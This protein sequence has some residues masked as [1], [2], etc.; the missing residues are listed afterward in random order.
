MARMQ[1][2][3][4]RHP[5]GVVVHSSAVGDYEVAATKQKIASNQDELVLRLTPTPKILDH[6]KRWAPSSRVV[7]FKAASPET[8]PARL[9]EIAQAQRRRTGS[10]LVFANVIGDLERSVWLV[11]DTPTA[12][13]DRGAAIAELVER[14]RAWL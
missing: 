10:D 4:G 6:L 13:T 5:T 12:F 7:S 8:T 9:V 1:A 14:V 2:W 11:D 3:L